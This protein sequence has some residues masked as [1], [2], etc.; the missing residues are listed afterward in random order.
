MIIQNPQ[1]FNK[2]E[3]VLSPSH[4]LRKI[5]LFRFFNNDIILQ[6]AKSV[7]NLIFQKIS[8]LLKITHC[9]LQPCTTRWL[10]YAL[11]LL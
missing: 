10:K 6:T 4:F 1:N 5:L 11:T 3:I 8:F 7:K 9:D 2:N